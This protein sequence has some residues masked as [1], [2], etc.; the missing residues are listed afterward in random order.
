[1]N[2]SNLKKGKKAPVNGST[3]RLVSIAVSAGDRSGSYHVMSMRNMRGRR[4]RVLI[5]SR[6]VLNEGSIKDHLIANHYPVGDEIDWKGIKR[7]LARHDVPFV[8]LAATPGFVGYAYLLP[9]GKCIG[10]ASSTRPYLDPRSE[11]VKPRVGSRG[12]LEGWKKQVA[13]KSIHSSRLLLSL[14]TAF[15]GYLARLSGIESGGFHLHGETSI[16]KSTCLRIATS[17]N[18]PPKNLGTWSMTVAGAEGILAGHNDNCVT[19]DELSELEGAPAKAAQTA[20]KFAYM[21]ASG[22]GKTRF[23]GMQKQ[24]QL[25][26]LK[27]CNSVLSTG[28]VSLDAHAILGGGDRRDGERV[29]LI[30]VPADAGKGLGIFESVPSGCDSPAEFAAALS[31]NA[32]KYYGTAQMAFL[33]QLTR[34]LTKDG[35]EV[36]GRLR[37]LMDRFLSKYDVRGDDGKKIRYCERFALAYAAGVFALGYNIMPFPE[38]LLLKKMGRCYMD[39][40]DSQPESIEDKVSKARERLRDLLRS[41]DYVEI[42]KG[43][44]AV[45]CEDLK[46]ARVLK[47]TMKGRPVKVVAASEIMKIMPDLAVR[48]QILGRFVSMGRLLLDANGKWTRPIPSGIP[49]CRLPRGYCFLPKTKGAT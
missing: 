36:K 30:D 5:P 20:S 16:G 4:R 10:S 31:Q 40:R 44:K 8:K 38:K 42:R 25:E 15:S 39:A 9:N 49:G 37:D 28:E 11:L 24:Y 19:L 17:V 43:G 21:S 34:D 48:Q 27:W 29:R 26:A 12:S 33:E 35:K 6:D 32:R 2:R 41:T 47:T 7:E 22:K 18:G 13:E 46:D 23:V 1:M 45:S 14:C 3:V